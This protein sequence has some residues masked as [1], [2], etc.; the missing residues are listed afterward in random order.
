M[1]QT[2]S[3]HWHSQAVWFSYEMTDRIAANTDPTNPATFNQY[4]GIDT[5]NGYSMDCQTNACTSG[6]MVTADAQDWT[7]M[8]QLLPGGRGV[9]S[10]PVANT[11][12]ISIMW[13]DNAGEAN[14]LNGEPATPDQT[15]YTVTITP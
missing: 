4:D 5:D 14:C 1:Q 7:N 13:D 2:A 6:Q 11:L 15:C 10:S 3:A 9:I 8:V 12:Q